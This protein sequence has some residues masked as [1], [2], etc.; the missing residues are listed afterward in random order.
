[1]YFKEIDESTNQ[2][3]Y[4]SYLSEQGINYS[5]R[6]G[7]MEKLYL[8]ASHQL[9]N[10]WGKVY[11]KEDIKAVYY[12]EVIKHWVNQQKLGLGTISFTKL[13]MRYIVGQKWLWVDSV[14]Y[15]ECYKVEM[16]A[17]DIGETIKAYF[18]ESGQYL[19]GEDIGDVEYFNPKTK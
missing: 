15:G 12:P 16:Y 4:L 13:N 5:L 2:E 18:N 19:G 9:V 10:E 1:M 11:E 14:I 3:V 17:K 6:N 8:N 7:L